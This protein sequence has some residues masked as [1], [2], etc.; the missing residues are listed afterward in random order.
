MVVPFY[1]KFSISNTELKCEQSYTGINV[2]H[3]PFMYLL[4]TI[5]VCYS[6]N[7]ERFA[8]NYQVIPTVPFKDIPFLCNS[9]HVSLAAPSKHCQNIVHHAPVAIF[10]LMRPASQS[11]QSRDVVLSWPLCGL[12][13]AEH[14]AGL[15]LK[16]SF[17]CDLV[18]KDLFM[19][20]QCWSSIGNLYI[21][22]EALQR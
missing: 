14:F 7:Y 12:L 10:L 8:V 16:H 2:W 9:Y 17:W 19:S 21:H 22:T 4:Q 5:K 3:V 6:I 11:G 15:G 1:N 13:A 20:M 18:S